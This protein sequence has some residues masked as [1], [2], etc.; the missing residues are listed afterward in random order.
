MAIFSKS[1][2]AADRHFEIRITSL[3][4]TSVEYLAMSWVCE[5][6]IQLRYSVLEMLKF[7]FLSEIA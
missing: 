4:T 2:M 1:K 7:L 5:N 6:V 3:K